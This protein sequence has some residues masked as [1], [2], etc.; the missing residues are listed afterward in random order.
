M[1][2]CEHV[3]RHVHISTVNGQ[4]C[5]ESQHKL[6]CIYRWMCM[7][8]NSSFL[9]L[10]L[11]Q[12]RFSESKFYSWPLLW[13]VESLVLLTSLII[14]IPKRRGTLIMNMY[15]KCAVPPWKVPVFSIAPLSQVLVLRASDS[16]RNVCLAGPNY[17]LIFP[18]GLV[19]GVTGKV[20][21]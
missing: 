2:P 17:L 3:Y 14:I 7:S 8:K 13:H 21:L 4:V 10:C 16:I 5:V 20:H 12:S 11:L 19:A 18:Y 6:R 9:A 1:C 15:P